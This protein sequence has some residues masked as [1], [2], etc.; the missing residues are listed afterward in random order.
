LSTKLEALQPGEGDDG[1]TGAHPDGN[2]PHRINPD[3]NRKKEGVTGITER[4]FYNPEEYSPERMHENG[5]RNGEKQRA[6]EDGT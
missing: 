2:M 6:A 4:R 3:L 1:E 5:C